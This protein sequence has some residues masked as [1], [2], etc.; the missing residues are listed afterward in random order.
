MN[1]LKNIKFI[2]PTATHILLIKDNMT[3]TIT[4]HLHVKTLHNSVFRFQKAIK[5]PP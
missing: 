2:F 1:T 4:F 3:N 5:C